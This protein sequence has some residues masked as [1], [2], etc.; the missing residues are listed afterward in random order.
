MKTFVVMPAYNEEKEIFKTISA[1][2]KFSK[3]VVVVDDGSTDLTA[4]K[5]R[6]AKLISL[7][8][9]SGKGAALRVGCDYAISKGAK[10]IISIDADGQHDPNMIPKFKKLLD[11]YDVVFGY[12]KFS[13]EMPLMMR[14]GNFS[15]S[16]LTRI[17]H[18]TRIY[19]TQCGYRAF[20]ADIY[21]KIRWKS[22]GYE[23]ESE[24]ISK[25]AKN[26]LKFAQIEV[27]TIYKD[28]Y[29]GTSA[30]S[31]FRILSN[32]VKWRMKK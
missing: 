30:F 28:N 1:V 32:V 17:L 20:R 27:K 7:V 6:N 12:R 18:G 10:K 3:N 5:V 19:D 15:I 25:V 8:V 11:K 24:M 21:D 2:R 31:G 13:K 23:V 9:N 4:K 26:K 22:E 16:F 14:I 29:K